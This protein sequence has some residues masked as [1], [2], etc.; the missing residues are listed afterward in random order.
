MF[1]Y[2]AEGAKQ[3][4]NRLASDVNTDLT[5]KEAAINVG[6][7]LPGI[8]TAMTVAEIEEELKKENPS[9][10]KIALLGGSEII[11]LIPGLG[12]AAKSALKAAAKKI[13]ANKI[14]DALDAPKPKTESEIIAGPGAP[15]Y[16]NEAYYKALQLKRR[17]YSDK[18]IE[19]ITGRLRTSSSGDY[20]PQVNQRLEELYYNKDFLNSRTK[21]VDNKDIIERELK[22][23]EAKIAQLEKKYPGGLIDPKEGSIFKFEIPDNNIKIKTNNG[24]IN[25][26]EATVN[27]P[28]LIGD[29]IPTHTKLFE[30]YPDLKNVEFYVDPEQSAVGVFD[31]FGGKLLDDGTGR[32]TGSI[33][34]NPDRMNEFDNINS[35]EF[36]DI[37]FHE[38][39]HAVQQQDYLIADLEQLAGSPTAFAQTLA[40]ES[41]VPPAFRQATILKNPKALK[42][43]EE[44]VALFKKEYPSKF[45]WVEEDFSVTDEGLKNINPKVAKKLANL[46]R[47]LELES[48]RTYLQTASEVEASVVGLRASKLDFDAAGPVTPEI[49]KRKNITTLEEYKAS[50][51]AF[52][53][54]NQ[55]TKIINNI[56]SK[57][58]PMDEFEQMRYHGAA[59]YFARYALG[60]DDA[61]QQFDLIG[62]KGSFAEGGT[63]MNKQMQMAF[64]NEGGLRDD[65]ME[66]DPVSGNEVPSGSMAK[67]VRDDIPAQL[68]EGEYVVP[69]DVVRYYGVKFFEDLRDRA[70]IGLQDM[71][72]NGRIG[73]EPVPAG[74]PTNTDEL[75]PQEMQAIQ[76]MM[77]M[78]EGGTVNMYKRQQDLYSAPQQAVGNNMMN[79]GGQVRGYSPGGMGTADMGQ[80]MEQQIL[81]AGQQVQP[82]VAQPLGSSLFQP[83]GSQMAEVTTPT[84]FVP[85]DM[86]NLQTNHRVKANTQQ[87]FDNYSSQ[88]YIVDDGTLKPNSGDS[89]GGGGG[90]NKPPKPE[91]WKKWLESA[92]F[93]SR[94]GLEKFVESLDYDPTKDQTTLKTLGATALAGPFAGAA[95]A[96]GSSKEG[97]TKISNLRAAAL[98]AKAQGF[99]DLSEKYNKQVASIIEKAPKILDYLDDVFAPGT[100]KA[101]AWA[102]TKGFDTIEQATEAGV[103]PTVAPTPTPTPSSNDDND[104]PNWSSA[105]DAASAASLAAANVSEGVNSNQAAEAAAAGVNA[106]VSAASSSEAAAAGATS[107][108]SG[109]GSTEEEGAETS[110]GT[111]FNKG[112]LATKKK[113]SQSKK[114]GLA[115]K[116]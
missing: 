50:K 95:T 108:G 73:G 32:R 74:G 92:D 75:S 54:D 45:K 105:T 85:V 4:A 40:K 41:I 18:Q 89:G 70:K 16:K 77:G 98:I 39:Q 82:F 97:L 46:M 17:G 36:R 53:V 15:D 47:D 33:S 42:I 26:K 72:A 112:G 113:K 102:K 106:G 84:A 107:I 38:L 10:G 90:G 52:K 69:A 27:S 48:H 94:G 30:Q 29:L 100:S 9:Y 57:F 8:G 66:K 43:K 88:G 6:S 96:L 37:F 19:E 67:E 35:K 93:N 12:T 60:M 51:D 24:V 21:T 91:G 87:E 5:F 116:K 23:V 2:T 28:I 3:E 63:V 109:E 65:N 101:N 80:N 20:I 115:G 1:G 86:I 81:T 55:V 49:S 64:M 62:V 61:L 76:E 78:A 59:V 104:P 34:I 68:S 14:I 58:K 99:D 31:P 114:G 103:T 79:E 11:G 44:I 56:K 71:E 25:Y 7:M 83:A 110:S 111:I 22:E 13:G